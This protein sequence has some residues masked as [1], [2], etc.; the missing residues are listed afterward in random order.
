VELEGFTTRDQLT[1][2]EAECGHFKPM[3]A[4]TKWGAKWEYGWFR[5]KPDG[6]MLVYVNGQEAGSI[7]DSWLGGI[8][9]EVTLTRRASADR[10]FR[11]AWNLVDARQVQ[12]ASA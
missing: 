2:Q 5:G 7:A 6:E 4:G 11:T 8:R 12:G 3:P 10:F 9:P 1:R